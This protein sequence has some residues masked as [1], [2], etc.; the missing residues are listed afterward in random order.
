MSNSIIGIEYQRG[1]KIMTKGI[2]KTKKKKE[3]KSKLFFNQFTL[4]INLSDKKY[5]NCKVF[6]NG[7]IQMTGCRSLLD[8]IEA[9]SIIVETI[10]KIG[11]YNKKDN[12]VINVKNY[13]IKLLNCIFSIGNN[14]EINRNKLFEYINNN[15]SCHKEYDSDNYPG[16]I[17][18][19]RH[20]LDIS[21][22]DWS[23]NDVCQWLAKLNCHVC[24]PIFYKNNIDGKKL[25][26]L[27]HNQI[28]EMGVKNYDIIDKIINNIYSDDVSRKITII[29]FR[30]GNIMITGAKKFE[31][32]KMPYEFITNLLKENQNELITFND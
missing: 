9:S 32:L 31:Q 7:K 6:T 17:I 4:N 21:R 26:S 22:Y 8:A 5:I 19:Y 18:K 23:V 12:S 10:D 27:G 13:K 2:I 30:T 16:V 3:I 28:Y 14:L 24:V 11:G 1:G 20:Y 15:T 25:I 29:V